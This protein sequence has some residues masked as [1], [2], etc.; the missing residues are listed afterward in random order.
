LVVQINVPSR[1]SVAFAELHHNKS[2][3][4]SPVIEDVIDI[5]E[6]GSNS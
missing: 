5:G 4:V 6:G 2:D 1:L 3:P